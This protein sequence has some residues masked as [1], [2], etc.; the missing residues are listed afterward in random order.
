MG[1][2]TP[3]FFWII[4]SL[5]GL[6][7]NVVILQCSDFFSLAGNMHDHCNLFSKFYSFIHLAISCIY[8]CKLITFQ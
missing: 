5:K 7:F 2:E 3:C 8:F 6:L 4:L 1:A